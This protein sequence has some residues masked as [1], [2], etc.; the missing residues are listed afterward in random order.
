M[1]GLEGLSCW[2]L[3]QKLEDRYW[4]EEG[5]MS[6]AGPEENSGAF[7]IANL[8]FQEGPGVERYYMRHMCDMRQCM[9]NLCAWESS[10]YTKTLP[11]SSLANA[12]Q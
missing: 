2:P 10:S 12:T 11:S 7:T 6:T 3:H 9:G 8:Y 4:W 5:E 1:V